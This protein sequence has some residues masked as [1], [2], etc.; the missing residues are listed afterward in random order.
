MSP[1]LSSLVLLALALKEAWRFSLISSITLH[2]FWAGPNTFIV[3]P[4]QRPPQGQPQSTR[5]TP[6]ANHRRYG[7]D[8]LTARE[9]PEYQTLPI[10][11]GSNS[12]QM[13]YGPPS[14][15][16]RPG[17]PCD[18]EGE[19][20]GGKGEDGDTDSLA[21]TESSDSVETPESSPPPGPPASLHGEDSGHC[22]AVGAFDANG[23]WSWTTGLPPRVVDPT[24]LPIGAPTVSAG[25]PVKA[26]GPVLPTLNRHSRTQMVMTG[27]P[28]KP[29]AH[30]RVSASMWSDIEDLA[31]DSSDDDDEDYFDVVGFTSYQTHILPTS[32]LQDEGHSTVVPVRIRLEE[33]SSSDESEDSI[34]TDSSGCSDPEARRQARLN[35]LKKLGRTVNI[36]PRHASASQ[37]GQGAPRR[38]PS[39]DEISSRIG[40]VSGGPS[41][42]GTS[43]HQ[44]AVSCPSPLLTQR[45]RF[46]EVE[47]MVTPPSPQ[48]STE[49]ILGVV[50][51]NHH[52][53][54]PAFATD[55]QGRLVAPAFD[56]APGR[57]I[58]LEERQ[59]QAKEWL[60]QFKAQQQA[61]P[62]LNLRLGT[63]PIAPPMPNG[64]QA[65]ATFA[66]SRPTLSRAASFSG[67]VS[68]TQALPQ[69]QHHGAPPIP[70][71]RRSFAHRRPELPVPSGSVPSPSI[72]AV[73]RQQSDTPERDQ[74]QGKAP[75]PRPEPRQPPMARRSLVARLS[76]RRPSREHKALPQ[77]SRKPVHSI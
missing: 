13:D 24:A 34:L 44:R 77:D 43:P 25:S 15:S 55:A 53:P 59:R 42:R 61:R 23:K 76:L 22:P 10:P 21:S 73:S 35:M 30:Q 36:P 29:S 54:W 26:A 28:H 49:K 50:L 41:R 72:S 6:A 62:G 39:L 40:A 5:S 19:M 65:A 51:R 17:V 9:M 31:K 56:V 68:D 71:R 60:E 52:M 70:P 58:L 67:H 8:K 11:I 45:E 20:S 16:D 12:K 1:S 74:S 46:G 63:G 2:V 66:K 27:S 47:V 33:D 32:T 57:Q 64:E 3:L 38:P 7:F 4:Q 18:N 75:A 14:T 37:L 48:M 69:T